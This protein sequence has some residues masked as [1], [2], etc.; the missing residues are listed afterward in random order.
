MLR[1]RPLRGIHFLSYKSWEIDD[2]AIHEY[3]VEAQLQKYSNSTNSRMNFTEKLWDF[4]FK[5]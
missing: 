1:N 5:I 3:N 4:C 2:G